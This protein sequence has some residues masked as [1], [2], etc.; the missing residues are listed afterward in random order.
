MSYVVNAKHKICRRQM[1]SVCGSPKCPVHSKNYT[2]GQHGPTGMKGILSDYGKQLRAKQQLKK[3]YGTISEKSF[4]KV[5]KEASRRKGDTSENLIGLLESRL[6]TVVFRSNFVPSIYGSRQ[7]VNHKHVKVNGQ[8][9]N[10]PSYR[11]KVGDVIEVKEKAK[12]IPMVIEATQ[13][14]DRNIPDYLEV[15]PKKMTVKL[16]RIPSLEDV[17]Y[18]VIMEPNLV[19][20]FYSR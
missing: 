9:I 18:P 2:P 11:L 16:V 20:E 6:D 17:P 4:K 3:H 10:I 15:D 19:I 7:L 5:Y 13:N 8:A 1:A 12:Q 14:Q